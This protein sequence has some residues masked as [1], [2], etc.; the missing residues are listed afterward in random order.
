MRENMVIVS[1]SG[2]DSRYPSLSDAENAGCFHPRCMHGI[3]TYYDGISHASKDGFRDEPRPVRAASPQYTARSRQRYMERQIRKYKDRAIVAQ[4]P[5]Q[6]M[7]A[8]NKV[9]EWEN[10]L[11]DLIESQPADNYLY[12]H[13]GRETPT[14]GTELLHKQPTHQW[15]SQEGRKIIP[16]AL[17]NKLIDPVIKSGGI[18][19]RGTEFVERHLRNMGAYASHLA[20]ALFFRKDATISDVLEEVY[21]YYQE[22][23]TKYSKYS[24]EEQEVRMEIDAKKYLLSVSEKY[25]IPPEETELTRQE[26]QVYE[27]RLA[28]WLESH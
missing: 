22:R 7:Q 9:R 19:E 5:Q 2:E 20:G 10:A 21:H 17:Y 18:V 28:D 12:R 24:G 3:S 15:V 25:K 13:R 1:V 23:G 27:R 11:D 16:E 8:M 4:T 14:E 6:K 26:L